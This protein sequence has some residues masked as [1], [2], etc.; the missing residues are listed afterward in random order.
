[1]RFSGF[2][3]DPRL[4]LDM[5]VVAKFPAYGSIINVFVLAR[6]SFCALYS[7]SSSG[8]VTLFFVPDWLRKDSAYIDTGV[9]DVSVPYFEGGVVID[10]L[11]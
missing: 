7:G 1:M 8:N 5:E 3:S 4:K 10:V 6:R 2:D 11:P 9:K